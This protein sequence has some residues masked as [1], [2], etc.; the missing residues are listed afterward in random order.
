MKIKEEL[1]CGFPVQSTN[2]DSNSYDKKNIVETIEKNFYINKDR[3]S[4]NL[5]CL[6]I[7]MSYQKCLRPCPQKLLLIFT[8]R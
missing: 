1:I 8:I 5:Y 6:Y 4:W 7:P 2:I 3:N